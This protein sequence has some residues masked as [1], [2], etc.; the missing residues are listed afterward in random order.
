M[1][2]YHDIRC[3]INPSPFSVHRHHVLR[4]SPP[5][6]PSVF[7]TK[8]FLISEKRCRLVKTMGKATRMIS[9]YIY[10]QQATYFAVTQLDFMLLVGSFPSKVEPGALSTHKLACFPHTSYSV[11]L[12]PVNKGQSRRKHA[13]VNLQTPK[14]SYL[15]NFIKGVEDP[16]HTDTQIQMIPCQHSYHQS[17]M[18]KI[19]PFGFHRP[20]KAWCW[21]RRERTLALDI[22]IQRDE[23]LK[24]DT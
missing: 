20:F 16:A 10:L 11:W 23:E 4:V 18:D 1:C 21:L 22:C 14:N 19:D 7:P 9:A 8:R 17:T 24:T 12:C 3:F 13:N 15:T 2:L 6:H 5:P